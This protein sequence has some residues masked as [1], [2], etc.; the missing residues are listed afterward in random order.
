MPIKYNRKT[1]TI[2]S[3]V[4]H[5]PSGLPT[6]G[7]FKLNKK[8]GKVKFID[9]RICHYKNGKFICPRDPIIRAKIAKQLGIKI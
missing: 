6:I 5:A 3:K 9:Y 2:F 4:V 8:T 1:E 7:I